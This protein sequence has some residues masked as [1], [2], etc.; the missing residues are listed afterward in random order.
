MSDA[1]C[2]PTKEQF[3]HYPW[4][5]IVNAAASRTRF[6]YCNAFCAKAA[7]HAG[8]PEE[9]VW[10][11]LGKLTM[12]EIDHDRAD[13]S[14][15]ACVAQF[16]DDEIELVK[17]LVPLV[18]DAELKA[19]MADIIW[20]NRHSGNF[21]FARIAIRAYVE[22]ARRLED[23]KEW[24][25]C[26]YR[27][28]RAFRLAQRLRNPEL[29]QPV[30]DH[31]Q[32]VIERC[33]GEDPLF[34]SARMM[35]LLLERNEGDPAK[36][37]PLAEKLATRAEQS[38]KYEIARQ[39]WTIL[40]GWQRLAA[41]TEAAK[42]AAV[43][44]AE[45]FVKEAEQRRQQP[46]APYLHACHHLEAAIKAL[47]EIPD[48]EARV[49]EL[50][51]LLLAWQEKS[52]SELATFGSERVD[53]TRIAERARQAVSGKS[54][55]EALFTLAVMLSPVSASAAKAWVEQ[56][57]TRAVLTSLFGSTRMN[58]K[59]RTIARDNGLAAEEPDD[60]N[61]ALRAK[62]YGYAAFEWQ[63]QAGA[64][65]D[66]ARLQILEEH[67]PRLRDFAAIVEKSGLV[68][69]G[70]E[71]IYARGL[72]AGLYGDFAEATHFL[73]P[74]LEHSLRWLI[75][76]D[77]GIASGLDDEGIQNEF[78]LNPM[79][80]LPRH[81]SRLVKLLGEDTVFDLR[82]VFVD[83]HGANLRNNMAHGLIN[84][85]DFYLPEARYGWWLILRLCCIPVINGVQEQRSADAPA[86]PA[87]GAG[88]DHD[89]EVKS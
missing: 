58:E 73:I 51:R 88:A 66:P 32:G 59:G 17:A 68:V 52:V 29:L 22:S 89:P 44:A 69:P 13:G 5:E 47:R 1:S 64:V 78:N 54:F 40:V 30:I 87:A 23:P 81:S 80:K 49:Q 61:E 50:H 60:A 41:D 36:Y 71:L 56:V 3:E 6:A 70:R 27:I 55:D 18:D 57:A 12:F 82:G 37:A 45:T 85:G 8:Q 16:G 14:I 9:S 28:E 43:R 83:A 65:I 79:L 21:P 72:H 77:G 10:R 63:S 67:S 75:Y 53:V 46:G 34:L 39:H 20:S 48:T 33:N 24:V 4:E 76:R 2:L 35:T 42:S 86:D 15:N 25:E 38:G 19:R 74:Q 7:A 26:E 84:S 11:F 31:I 62:M